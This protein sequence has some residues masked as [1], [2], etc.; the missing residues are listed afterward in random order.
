MNDTLNKMPSVGQMFKL[1]AV[2]LLAV[3]AVALVMAL[4]KMLLPLAILAALVVGGIML[5][6]R[7]Q[8]LSAA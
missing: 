8:K 2:L 6:K 7:A 4:V 1:V 5:V 3:I